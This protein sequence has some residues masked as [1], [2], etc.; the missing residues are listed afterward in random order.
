MIDVTQQ[1]ES[2]NR[3]VGTRVLEDGRAHVVGVSRVYDVPL[4]DLWDA[5]SNPE[6]IPLWFL[7]VTGELRTGGHYQLE[8]NAGGTVLRCE[9][10]VGFSATWEYGEELSWIEVRLT[11]EDG[12]ARFV[13]EHTAHIEDERW[14]EY[15]PGAV[16]VGWDLMLVGLTVHLST[17]AAVD[18]R[19]AM[20]WSASDEGRRFVT[21]SSDAWYRANVAGGAD[22]RA[23]R[24][25][26]DRT[27]AFY[28]GA[29]DP[30][31]SA[32]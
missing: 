10:P 4:E 2:V 7:P 28:T 16:G 1:I 11:R 27:T 6:R 21:A 31:G 29:D 22:P 30:G 3:Q 17:G 12:G 8:G 15:G 20:L 25:S 18:P 5:C 13:L 26:A 19:E 9:P 23:A 24:A 32:G 14:T